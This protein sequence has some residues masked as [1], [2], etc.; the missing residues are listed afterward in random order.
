MKNK[1]HIFVAGALIVSSLVASLFAVMP[2]SA[3]SNT[4]RGEEW[5]KSINGDAP[6]TSLSIPGSHD[7]GATHSFIDLSGKCQDLSI[8]DQLKAGARFF[9]I[10]LKQKEAALTV[11]HGFVE[12]D[13]LFSDVLSTFS[14]FLKEHTSEG[15]IVSVKKEAEGLR[16][17]FTFD[18][19]LKNSLLPYSNIWNISGVLPETLKELR[20]KIFLISRYEESTIGLKAYEGWL[21]PKEA[22]EKNTFDIETSNLHV[23]DH[24]KIK[25]IED[26]KKE[27]TECFE[28][29]K[30]NKEVLTLNF[31]SCYYVNAYPPTYAGSSAVE[32]NGW[33][34]EQFKNRSNLGVIVADFIT[35]SLCEAIYSRN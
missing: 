7:A 2:L 17:A 32:I 11:V 8:Q 24:Y 13:L 14:S 22:S 34:T 23:Q 20:G 28:F 16:P 29:S 3:K 4:N 10:R 27:I 21:D 33:I 15:L 31:A 5:M 30:N 9:D 1:T 26:K 35:S 6:I 18:E 19:A 25:D 12:Q